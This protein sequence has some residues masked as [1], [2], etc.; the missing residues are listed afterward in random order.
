MQDLSDKAARC[1]DSV[2]CSATL[3]QLR[4]GEQC[5]FQMIE[6]WIPGALR[7][8]SKQRKLPL[9]ALL[10]RCREVEVQHAAEGG[11]EAALKGRQLC[12][13]QSTL[14]AF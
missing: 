13:Q 14:T 7:H 6:A 11:A 9:H 2:L 1:T 3:C 12:A 8:A 5:R 10:C 4:G